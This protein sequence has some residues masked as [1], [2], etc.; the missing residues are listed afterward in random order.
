MFRFELI[1]SFY[2]LIIISTI[3]F[4]QVVTCGILLIIMAVGNFANTV[5]TLLS[6][7]RFKAKMKKGKIKHDLNVGLDS[8]NL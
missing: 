6:K 8:K 7:S 3:C 4:W 2:P 1:L 5:Q